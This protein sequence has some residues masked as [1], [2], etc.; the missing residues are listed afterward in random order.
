MWQS[1]G[2]E[3]GEKILVFL[4]LLPFPLR[5]FLRVKNDPNSWG[6]VQG[7]RRRRVVEEE[8]EEEE[9]VEEEGTNKSQA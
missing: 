5:F 7:G 9:E 3:E 4:F 2:G 8:E 6:F 1:G